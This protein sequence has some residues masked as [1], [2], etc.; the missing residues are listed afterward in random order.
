MS[1]DK[2]EVARHFNSSAASKAEMLAALPR[3]VALCDPDVEWT[4]RGARET[5]RG[6]EG[7]R[8]A[9]ERWL[10]SF[11]DYSYEA[12]RV[13]DCGDD[14]VLVV[15]LEVG[16]GAMSGVEVR[17]LNY[18]LLTI[19]DGLIVRYREFYDERE[20]LEAAGLEE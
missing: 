12:Q 19:R 16:T 3:M 6:R 2:V 17:S 5:S 20:A 1:Q 4:Q 9:L 13:V 18:E 15:G 7:V 10:D 14:H 8:D 11:E